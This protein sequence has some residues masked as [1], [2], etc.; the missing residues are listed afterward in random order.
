M[1]CLLLRYRGKD[2][3]L[4]EFVLSFIHGLYKCKEL[5]KYIKKSEISAAL[6]LP[7]L[8]L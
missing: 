3:G 2:W 1:E 8:L 7:R 6:E 4:L 5:Q